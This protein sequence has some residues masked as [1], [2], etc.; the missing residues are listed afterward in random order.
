MRVAELGRTVARSAVLTALTVTGPALLML[1][2]GLDDASPVL[3][4]AL[5]GPAAL[6]CWV[7]GIIVL[8]HEI[9]PDLMSTAQPLLRR[10]LPKPVRR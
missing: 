1:S 4:L 5:A 7:S 6:A 9:K 10:L 2:P 3:L 8:N